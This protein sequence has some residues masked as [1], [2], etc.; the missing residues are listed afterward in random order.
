M[1]VLIVDD[2]QEWRENL[3]DTVRLAIH[4]T[5]ECVLAASLETAQ[6]E[7]KQASFALILSDLGIPSRDGISD[8][9][10]E[11]GMLLLRLIRSNG[12]NQGAIGIVVTSR[13][14]PT[15]MREVLLRLNFSD[16]LEKDK[17]DQKEAQEVIRAALFTG[18]YQ[19]VAASQATKFD[20]TFVLTNTHCVFAELSGP[21]RFGDVIPDQ[22]LVFEA[23]ESIRRAD[24][25]RKLV[26]GDLR[27]EM[28][29]EWRTDAR[30]TGM[31]LYR[32]L[33]GDLSFGGILRAGSEGPK[34]F[35]DLRL[36]FRGTRR[37]LAVPFE[38]LHNNSEYLALN[39]P[40]VRQ[41]TSD[42]ASARKAAAFRTSLLKLHESDKTLN[43]LLLASNGGDD[44]EAADQ[45][46][47]QLKTRI[48]D[49]LAETGVRRN[50]LAI[51]T[52]EATYTRVESVLRE[53]KWHVIHYAGH[54]RWNPD[55]PEDS[56]LIFMHND[57]PRS[58]PASVLHDLLKDSETLL[59]FLNGCWGA[60]TAEHSE[61]GDLYGLMDSLV[62]AGT[63]IVLGHRW[64]VSD[65]AARDLA[66]T[67][68]N[69]LLQNWSAEDALL[70]A[71]KAVV[72]ESPFHG[73][74]PGW[75]S[76]ILVVQTAYTRC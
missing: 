73:D 49:R 11:N 31:G 26:T 66:L 65:G 47:T 63:P 32:S 56:A 75:A 21:E 72:S 22:P 28:I 14:T 43:V 71:R 9:S 15:R 30:E 33:F 39:H 23:E 8:I 37:S 38:L 10:P 16:F 27:R 45:E 64:S 61:Q 69:D 4:Q 25:I 19:R 40:L 17:F 62:Q 54:G 48:D 2:E 46:V 6:A 58:M 53:R 55:L 12:L 20:L 1:R 60:R 51:S 42:H 7:L 34:Q 13:G 24:R 35:R 74:D 50:V 67:F 29:D 36:C 3:C 41:V 70:L 68:Y 44:L 52:A 18:A 76:P 5:V 59:F 57:K